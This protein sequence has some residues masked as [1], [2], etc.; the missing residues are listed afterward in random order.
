MMFEN[1]LDSLLKCVRTSFK[2]VS[3]SFVNGSGLDTV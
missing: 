2:A 1:G 3:C